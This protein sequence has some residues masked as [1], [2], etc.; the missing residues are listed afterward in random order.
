MPEGDIVTSSDG[1]AY[2]LKDDSV[3]VLSER[4]YIARTIPFVKPDPE[5]VPD[6]VSVSG[7]L[8]AIDLVKVDTKHQGHSQFLVLY[9][10]TGEPYGSY[11]TDN[12]I[13]YVCFL[14]KEGFLIEKSDGSVTKL[15]EEPLQ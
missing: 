6:Q 12:G 14:G 9:A 15:L 11:E 5:E 3:V 13:G 7:G 4:G 2:F 8:L 10:V 1:N